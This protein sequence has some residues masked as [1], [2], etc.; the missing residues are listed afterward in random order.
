MPTPVSAPTILIVDDTEVNVL[1]LQSVLDAEG[2]RTLTASDGASA[3][4]LSRTQTPDLILL[5]VVMPGESGF[6]TCAKLKSDPKTAD[7]P[8]IF[9]SAQDD[10]KSKVRGLKVGGVD[11]VTKPVH[12][13][14]VLAR[15]RVHLRIGETNR[16]ITRQH[17]AQIE[18]LR[19]AQQA[20]L[21]RPE[22]CPE[23]SFAVYY[24]PLEGAGGDFYDVVA[25]D[26]DVFGYFVADVSG[27]GASAAFLTS[28]IKALLRQYSGPLFSAE[29]TMRGIDTVMR[30]MLGEEQYLTAC[31]A[32]LNRRTGRL[33]VVSA[34]H[35]PVIVVQPSGKAQTLQLD[36][37]PLG[38]FSSL[39]IQRKEVQVSPG[40]RFYLYTDGFIESSPGGGREEGLERLVAA[41]VLRQAD[42]LAASVL[43]IAASL[44]VG[45]A[46]VEDDLLLLAVEVPK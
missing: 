44:R 1:L 4:E 38:I 40:D 28:A 14:E 12:G 45:A 11:Y 46:A 35:P 22:S 24:E 23:A 29:D 31:Y 7:I 33:S 16:A 3:R 5:D 36:S 42:R 10:V 19:N 21:V 20:I 15:V 34:G 41:C 9:L 39:V 18:E 13:E 43:A 32:N 2:F 17:Q 6:E 25:V 8:I 27:H 26:P 37:D 30:Q